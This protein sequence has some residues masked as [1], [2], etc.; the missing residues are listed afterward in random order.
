MGYAMFPGNGPER[1]G[2][3]H[4]FANGVTV[5]AGINGLGKTT[6]LNILL[7]LIIGP[8]D[9]P[10]EDPE[11]VGSTRHEIIPWQNSAYFSRRVPDRAAAAT[12]SG[13][14]SF[15]EQ[16]IYIVRSL[17]DLSLR[18]LRNG[19]ENI[20][21]DE[22]EYRKLAVQMSGVSNFYDFHFVVRNLL[23]YLEDRRPLLWSDDGQFEIAR[24]LFVPGT[25]STDLS[26]EYDRV[27]TIDSRYRNLLTETNRSVR[28]LNSQQRAENLKGVHIA[29]ISALKT[30]F[31]NSQAELEALD[32]VL[33][34]IIESERSISEDIRRTQLEVEESLRKYE[35][36]QQ[37]FF[38]NAFPKAIESF[39]YILAHIVSN[40]GCLVCGSKAQER[41][42]QLR[43]QAQQGT[44]P[45]CGTPPEGQENTSHAIASAEEVNWG[46][47]EVQTKQQALDALIVLREPVRKEIDKRFEHRRAIT[48]RME[49]QQAQLA[50]L[51]G[52]LPSSGSSLDELEASVRVNQ[53]NLA[54][55]RKDRDEGIAR[56]RSLIQLASDRIKSVIA[57]VRTHFQEYVKQ[58]LAEI[59]QLNYHPRMRTIGQSGERVAFPGFDVLMT[60]GAF[61]EQPRPRMGVD[62]ISE[63]QKE[64]IDLAFRMALIRTAASED[65]GAM[66]VL[67]TPEASLDSLFV[68]RAG[69]L[70][71]QFSEA[72]GSVGNVLIASSNLSDANM[73][74]ALL[75]I[76]RDPSL[77]ATVP[78]HVINLLDVAAPNRALTEQRDAYTRQYSNSTIPNPDRIPDHHEN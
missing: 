6:L 78:S 20:P 17:R 60:S 25:E 43:Q 2:L 42:A 54:T 9:V 75:G 73:I 4:D 19:T 61:P 40:A 38:A 32:S 5:I 31:M 34:D 49:E 59:C 64:F 66:L 55:L 56:Y 27:R 28:R 65:G 1:L 22:A 35:G 45:V 26:V 36:L 7:R 48:T 53:Q 71:R 23:F 74:P 51:G 67:E 11:D 62:E 63:S 58:F 16:T 76:D 77:A 47:S 69:D 18:E 57:E 13:Q 24:I 70:L 44:C 21:P 10:R 14:I 72:G 30:G 8:G 52:K 39:H 68:Y 41:A 12:V 46:L 3:S 50:A 15:G 37:A 29:K 33:E